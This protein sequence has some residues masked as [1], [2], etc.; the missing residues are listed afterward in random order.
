[1]LTLRA[2]ACFSSIREVLI[3][4]PHQRV[5]ILF[6]DTLDTDDLCSAE[7]ATSIESHRFQPEFCSAVLSLHMD[8]RRLMS[9][10]GI[11]EQSV[12]SISQDSRQRSSLQ[13]LARPAALGHSSVIQKE[14]RTAHSELPRD[15]ST[16]CSYVGRTFRCRCPIDLRCGCTTVDRSLGHRAWVLL[17][18]V[19]LDAAIVRDFQFV[20]FCGPTALK[21]LRISLQESAC[22]T[23]GGD[24]CRV[25]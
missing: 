9:I 14:R 7:A 16:T 2:S 24:Q 23:L 8:M 13:C 18:R 11:E 6:D 10:G 21:R 4:R 25:A 17:S 3:P 20:A 1:M 5:G 12:G 19:R 15:P 22:R